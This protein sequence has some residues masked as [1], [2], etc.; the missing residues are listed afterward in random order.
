MAPK[1][2]RPQSLPSYSSC[3]TRRFHSCLCN[4]RNTPSNF[5]RQTRCPTSYLNDKQ[6]IVCA[7]IQ[8]R[9]DHDC[10]SLVR[11]DNN[12]FLGRHV[13]VGVQ[14]QRATEGQRDVLATASRQLQSGAGNVRTKEEIS[15]RQVRPTSN[16]ADQEETTSRNVD[17][18]ATPVLVRRRGMRIIDNW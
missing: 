2:H 5:W 15:D 8:L 1:A 18:R 4:A 14:Q 7:D 16:V 11:L 12:Y 10:V 3:D 17:V 6:L 13:Y 9:L